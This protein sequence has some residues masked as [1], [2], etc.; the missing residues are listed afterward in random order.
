MQL[1]SLFC[2]VEI[3]DAVGDR[4]DVLMDGGVQRERIS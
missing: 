1:K 3:V 2:E 4:I